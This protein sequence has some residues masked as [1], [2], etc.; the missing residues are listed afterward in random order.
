MDFEFNNFLFDIKNI[1]SISKHVSKI[2]LESK[3]SYD[4]ILNINNS[5]QILELLNDDINKISI[6]HNILNLLLNVSNLEK[7][8]CI[9]NLINKINTFDNDLYKNKKIYNKI[10][11]IDL[12]KQNTNNKL[13]IDKIINC[14][15]RNGIKLSEEKYKKF[16]E[17]K[18]K[19]FF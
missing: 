16:I 8:D 1:K 19:Y 18:K 5:D 3:K 13:F 17:I 7:K 11:S 4:K 15:E 10:K 12:N 2:L 9:V 6:T 14:Y